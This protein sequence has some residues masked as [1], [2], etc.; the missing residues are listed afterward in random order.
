MTEQGVVRKQGGDHRAGRLGIAVWNKVE[1]NSYWNLAV[2]QL[3][4]LFCCG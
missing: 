3:G 2:C 1:W 4:L